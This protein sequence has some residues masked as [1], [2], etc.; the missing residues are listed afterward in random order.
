MKTRILKLLC[1]VVL[2]VV[3]TL[4]FASCEGLEEM[5]P[6]IDLGIGGEKEHVHT[7]GE[8]YG[9]TATCTEGGTK[10][11]VCTDESCN[12]KVTV[13]TDPL[14]HDIVSYEA[15]AATCTEVGY[16]AYE[17]C[18]RCSYS[19]YDEYGPLGHDEVLHEGDVA[20]CTKGGYDAYVTCEKCDY[21]TYSESAPL[22]HDIVSHE[23]KAATCT[24]GG[25]LAYE[26]CTRCDHTTYTETAPLG[27]DIAS[28]EAKAPTCTEV[29]YGAYE[30]CTRCDYTT[31]NE[32]KALGHDTVPHEAKAATCTEGGH[33]A[34][35]TC[36]RCD[37]TTYT[38]TSPLG[39]DTVSHEAKAATCTD[40]GYLAY[41]TCTRCDYTTYTE[42]SAL[43][44]EY[45][46]DFCIRCG[47]EDPGIIKHSVCIKTETG[48]DIVYLAK[49]G[50]KLK[51]PETPKKN[52]YTFV[53]WFSGDKEWNFDVDVLISDV[54][55]YAKW[56]VNIYNITYELGG[57]TNATANPGTF[58][59]ETGNVTL[60][61]PS[62][63][64]YTFSGWY[65]DS[66][67]TKPITVINVNVF[68]N[69]TIYAKWEVN[70]YNI[71][72]ELGGGTNATA[73]PGTFDAETGNV[74]LA[75]PSKNGYTF[76]GWYSDSAYTK[77]ITVINVN[78]FENVTIYAKWE[79]NIYNI[80]YELNGGTNAAENPET[81]SIES[82]VITFREPT[83]NGYIF[84]GWYR[85]AS[86]TRPISMIGYNVF[87]NITIYAKWEIKT[88][89]IKYELNGGTNAEANPD[90]F[91][92]E[93]G[94]ITLAK[95]TKAGWAFIGWYSDPEFVNPVTEIDPTTV[96]TDISVY[97]K[98]EF[99]LTYTIKNNEVTV[100]GYIGTET[101]V[102]IPGEIEGYPVVA[103]EQNAFVNNKSITELVVE[104]GVE[105]IG[106]YAFDGCTSLRSITLAKTV[107]EIDWYAFRKTAIEEIVI[108]EGVV[109]IGNSAFGSCSNLVS[110]TIPTT[111]TN[112]KFDV[113]EYC[114]NIENVYIS[115]FT[116]WFNIV[117]LSEDANPLHNGATLYLDGE[118]VTEIVIP[119]GITSIGDYAFY[120]YKTAAK[121]SIPDS[122]TSIGIKAFKGCDNLE[123]T[124]YGNAYY[125]G[126]EN[127]PYLYL[128]AKKSLDITTC[129]IHK[130]TKFISSDAFSFARELETI[131][132]DAISMYDVPEEKFQIYYYVGVNT[133]GT[134]V[135]IGKDVQRI[136]AFLFTGETKYYSDYSNITS[137][138]F[139]EGSVCTEIG[140][141]AFGGYLKI[142]TLEI[143]DSVT[144][145][146]EGAFY[147]CSS[148]TSLKLSNQITVLPKYMIRNTKNLKTLVVPEGVTT[149]KKYSIYGCTSIE[150]VVLPM[151]ITLIE[152][153]AF[154][155][156]N[157]IGKIFYEGTEEDFSK[158]SF[159]DTDSKAYVAFRYFYTDTEPT[160]QG[161]FWHYVDGE[162]AVWTDALPPEEL[163]FALSSDETYYIVSG[164][165]TFAGNVITIPETYN[166]LPVLEI[167]LNAFKGYSNITELIIEANLQK[168]GNYAFQNCTSLT[169]ITI[170]GNVKEIGAF[171]FYNCAITEL[172]L[173]EGVE[174]VR[175][176]AFAYCAKLKSITIPK[177]LKKWGASAN[178]SSI[179]SVYISDLSAWLGIEFYSGFA[180]NPFGYGADLY[181][182]GELVTELI[183]PEGTVGINDRAF[184]YCRS[185]KK[186]VI[187]S[188]VTYIG[189]SAFSGC[190]NLEFNMYGNAYYLGNESNPYLYLFSKT[191]TNITECIIH[192]DAKFIANEA[193][194]NARNLQTIYFNAVEM[195]DVKANHSIFE[196]VGANTEG[197]KI[198]VGKD[199][200][201]IPAYLFGIVTSN[202]VSVEFEEGS[203]CTEIG[204]YAFAYS[205]KWISIEIPDSVTSMGSGVFYNC[206]TLTNVKL[207]SSITV[208]KDHLFF[209]CANITYLVIPEGVE[210][211]EQYVIYGCDN[212]KEIVIPKSV[213]EFK[214]YA[215]TVP[216]T[217]AAVYYSGTAEEWNQ[218]FFNHSNQNFINVPR[219][220]YSETAPT[221]EGNFWYYNENG[222]VATWGA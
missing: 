50:N 103:I 122:V 178:C 17:A 213:T 35:E 116:A 8:W 82:G 203:V 180:S 145:I 46:D 55:I 14:G 153:G 105:K 184:S 206:K 222:E 168:I 114:T 172:V 42:T 198:I 77:P 91:S 188:S 93:S 66:A 215:I 133:S 97:A 205:N 187:P 192:K 173:P 4:S 70:I 131:Y 201:R 115:D 58:D 19:T 1:L 212:L 208:L 127:N 68:E 135:I 165:G 158:I 149:I 157:N 117:F 6:G 81:F 64:G 137:I 30:N 10:E 23:A 129:T 196:Y 73:N 57:G 202:I 160:E 142:S 124:E 195:A 151:S 147:N 162:I 39:H 94:V 5:I 211:I 26:T 148:L 25:Y 88:Y 29:G 152:N 216:S 92:A 132:F 41:E 186:V 71:T 86:C 163:E 7:F 32:I 123:F 45:V 62:K 169:N 99:T 113:F 102:V 126:N 24:E 154:S 44:H 120:G 185:I 65:S 75:S 2:T 59:A 183:I 199:V 79:V 144:V 161:F 130:D 56:E 134:K 220:Y 16:G 80:T 109:T 176:S 179:K 108:P 136:P 170:A 107:K 218:I 27:H 36:T 175:D 118:A 210:V 87:E 34:Y 111:L 21:T 101:K 164:I 207:S 84:E 89:N 40:G 49:E 110:V 96:A 33:L 18:T 31:Y 100:T 140:A 78:V 209:G 20:T 43:G 90:T 69:V 28:H 85:D 60:A 181:L 61:S 194:Y 150:E 98:W 191:S 139:E 219:Y 72:Y 9:D 167:G 182:N 11:R 119:E 13:G 95:P 125:I 52:G 54:T 155:G 204:N 63:N 3:L 12:K 121:I 143:P 177:T 48:E 138:E 217:L 174:T 189:G 67:Y 214:G 197:A 221:T 190:E 51:A 74:T 15:K 106:R 171:A 146:N 193:F 53:G 22:G 200:K 159:K 37:Y 128:Y 104:D 166:D 38:A 76:S 156:S 47:I 141:Y 112:A 83:K